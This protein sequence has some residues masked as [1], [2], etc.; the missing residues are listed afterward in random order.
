LLKW[1]TPA[2][3]L[4]AFL[5]RAAAA[6][7]L[8][9]DTGGL[10]MVDQF[11][12]QREYLSLGTALSRSGSLSFVDPRFRQPV[13]AFRMPVYPALIALV[14]AQ[15]RAV[16]ILQALAG[17]LTTC[18]VILMT[19]RLASLPPWVSPL[20][21]LL[22][23]INPL[24]VATSALVLTESLTALAVVFTL[25]GLTS[26][27]PFA[28]WSA[29]VLSPAMVLITPQWGGFA[30][31]ATVLAVRLWPVAPRYRLAAVAVSLLATFLFLAPWAARNR[32]L[33]GQWLPLTTAGG[34]TLFDGFGP[35]ANGSSNLGPTLDAM[36][37]LSAM[38]E[39]ER[40]QLLASRATSA[41][42]ADPARLPLLAAA[43]TARTF[44]PIPLTSHLGPEKAR[45]TMPGYAMAVVCGLTLFLAGFALLT[46]GLVLSGGLLAMPTLYLAMIVSLSIGSIRYR[47]AIEPTVC[48]LAAVGVSNLLKSRPTGLPPA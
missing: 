14:G 37:Q 48:L 3:C 2:V 23:A 26:R 43:K 29:A 4:L 5:L 19:R 20:A 21:G 18:G 17:A 25:V 36:P 38:T 8:P 45:N 11:P 46:G 6:W 42:R 1:A 10:H 31:L 16:Q 41:I 15:P 39:F 32:L 9:A 22:V 40:H 24:S 35:Q 33:L 30:F 13:V 44:S 7:Y 28:R 27:H 47:A 12:D 34:Q